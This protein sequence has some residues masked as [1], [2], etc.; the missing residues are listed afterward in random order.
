MNKLN[1]SEESS[2]SEPNFIDFISSIATSPPVLQSQ[3][4][5]ILRTSK[6]KIEEIP[7]YSAI[8]YSSRNKSTHHMALFIETTEDDKLLLV[9]NYP[10]EGVSFR[11][12][13]KENINN[14]HLIKFKKELNMERLINCL[15][16]NY[17]YSG[18]FNNCQHF[19]NYIFDGEHESSTIKSIKNLVSPLIWQL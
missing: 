18:I 3:N 5:N 15:V 4:P 10:G 1:S 19:V 16:T 8:A 11:K 12:I 6:C 2:D 7:V 13:S 14:L 17:S 9:D